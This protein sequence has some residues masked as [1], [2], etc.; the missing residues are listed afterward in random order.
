MAIG[1]QRLAVTEI[2][3]WCGV[4]RSTVGYWIRTGKLPADRVGRDYTVPTQ[5]LLYF[6]NTTGRPV[7]EG[8]R[9]ENPIGSSFQPFHFCWEKRLQEDD[10][11]SCMECVVYKKRMRA[12]FGGRRHIAVP[13]REIHCSRCGYYSDQ[14]APRIEFIH[15]IDIPAVVYEDLYI[16]GGNEPFLN[17]TRIV[18]ESLP[19]YDMERLIHPESLGPVISNIKRRALGC[20]DIPSRYEI[21]IRKV[22]GENERTDICVTPLKEPE[23]TFLILF[24]PV[25]GKA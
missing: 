2:A 22:R 23:G 16:W 10:A 8:L 14:V 1:K 4:G 21:L 19:G 12:C 6:L 13:G 18:K 24:H 17:W 7:P 9:R 20:E 11:R 3:E 5:D 15:Q 25:R